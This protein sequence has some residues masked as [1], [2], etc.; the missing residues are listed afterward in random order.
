MIFAAGLVDPTMGMVT[1]GGVGIIVAGI[2]H[3]TG[4][5]DGE[6]SAIFV[7]MS[8]VTTLLVPPNTSAPRHVTCG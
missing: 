7:G 5:I 2:G 3:V 4:V 6:L 1:R 8:I